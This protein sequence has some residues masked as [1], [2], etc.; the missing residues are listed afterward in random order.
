MAAH[1][2]P[3]ESAE[4]VK[5]RVLPSAVVCTDQSRLYRE[6]IPK[7]GYQ[8]KRVHH[9]A[10]VYVDGDT[11]TQTIEGFWSLVKRGISG[12]HHS[13]SAKYLQG[14]LNEYAWRYNH[15]A[16]SRAQFFG[17]LES[18]ATSAGLGVPETALGGG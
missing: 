2:V 7:A 18:G 5:A 1:V 14:Y 11:H 16:D 13:V 8:H 15:R 17:I 12:S 6:P 10:K 3:L 4:H 9:E